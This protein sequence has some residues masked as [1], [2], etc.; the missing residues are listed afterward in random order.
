M[1]EGK[2]NENC[3]GGYYDRIVEGNS[4]VL[5]L[6]ESKNISNSY[7]TVELQPKTLKIIQ[8]RTRGN[9]AAPDKVVKWLE[10]AINKIKQKYQVA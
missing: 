10:K 5:F 8:C 7:C 3:V 1:K 9:G 2:Q 6:R 4:I